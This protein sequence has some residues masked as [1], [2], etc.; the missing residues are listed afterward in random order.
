MYHKRDAFIVIVIE[1]Q[2]RKSIHHS[3][4]ELFEL[5]VEVDRSLGAG[6]R[7][8]FSYSFEDN[9]VPELES[10]RHSRVVFPRLNCISNS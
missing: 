8:L 4:L 10:F 9:L 7:R 1:L 5:I 6:R 3:C 2:G